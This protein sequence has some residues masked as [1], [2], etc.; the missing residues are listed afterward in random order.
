MSEY[1]KQVGSG[2]MCVSK[3]FIDELVYLMNKCVESGGNMIRFKLPKV[4]K[5]EPPYCEI[6]FTYDR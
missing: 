5:E 3:D 1:E 6:T 4:G 2:N